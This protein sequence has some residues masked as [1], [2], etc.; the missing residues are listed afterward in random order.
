MMPWD[1]YWQ[2][3]ACHE[4]DQDTGWDEYEQRYVEWLDR[5]VE[6]QRE[7]LMW[8]NEAPLLDGE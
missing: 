4:P 5:E 7:A 2:D 1:R 6:A 8:R 3:E